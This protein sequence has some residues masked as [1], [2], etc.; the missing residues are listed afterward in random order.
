MRPLE[1]AWNSTTPHHTY[2]ECFSSVK[3]I[4]G[5]FREYSGNIQ[6]QQQETEARDGDHTHRRSF[7]RSFGHSF[8]QRDSRT[9]S[10][11]VCQS[12]AVLSVT[13]SH[14]QSHSQ[15]ARTSVRVGFKLTRHIFHCTYY[16]RRKYN[17]S[18]R[19]ILTSD[20]NRNTWKKKRKGNESYIVSKTYWVLYIC[21][22][23]VS[24]RKALLNKWKGNESYILRSQ[25]DIVTRVQYFSKWNSLWD[26]K[27]VS[28]PARQSASET[29]SQVS[30]SVEQ[31]ARDKNRVKSSKQSV[32]R[33]LRATTHDIPHYMPA[34]A[35]NTE[36]KGLRRKCFFNGTDDNYRG[37]PKT[38]KI[39][40]TYTAVCDNTADIIPR[41]YNDRLAGRRKQEKPKLTK[42]W[43]IRINFLRSVTLR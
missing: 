20:F 22:G 2:R 11:Q 25:Q 36:I 28:E 37:W 41:I 1:A 30:Q 29:G 38:T 3:N 4:Q 6:R 13:Q 5:I 27:E 24:Y 43:E 31:P 23:V 16:S 33:R 14:L 15:P 40:Q 21:A 17:T 7:G 10:H 9:A 12:V 32:V 35:A 8:R 34:A 19:L 42:N 18:I 39:Q 26:S